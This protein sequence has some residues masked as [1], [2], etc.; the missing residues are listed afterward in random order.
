[1]LEFSQ[2]VGPIVG[3]FIAAFIAWIVSRDKLSR[4][5]CEELSREIAKEHVK[6]FVGGLQMIEDQWHETFERMKLQEGRIQARLRKEEKMLA[7]RAD[8]SEVDAILAGAHPVPAGKN[9]AES[10]GD[11]RA[12]RDTML[13]KHL[14]GRPSTP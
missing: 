5:Q 12:E 9:L 14:S 8:G 2:L 13:K 11:R 4:H 6:P 7:A 1:M 3:V 10:T